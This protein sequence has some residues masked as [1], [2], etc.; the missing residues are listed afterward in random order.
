MGND[1]QWRNP[2]L[3]E[4]IDRAT[5]RYG[6]FVLLTAA[7]QRYLPRLDIR[8]GNNPAGH[9]LGELFISTI[10]HPSADRSRQ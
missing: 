6:P 4:W 9:S 1:D 7:T 3:T 10:I 5:Y 8:R 2:Y